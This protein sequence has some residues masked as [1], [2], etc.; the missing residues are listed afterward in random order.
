MKVGT[1]VIYTEGVDQKTKQPIEF[2]ALVLGERFIEH[3]LGEDDEPLLTLAFAKERT[4]A[5][6]VPLPVH[7]TGQTSELVQIRLDVVHESHE[8][9]E[10]KQ[11][12]YGKKQYDGG[13]WRE[14]AA[15][16]PEQ[17]PEQTADP[18]TPK[19]EV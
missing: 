5:A 18:S 9:S 12:E 10:E 14:V 2:N 15:R 11:R 7:G 3:H 4:D 6:G 17:A 19:S 13:R 8:Y 16:A 1:V